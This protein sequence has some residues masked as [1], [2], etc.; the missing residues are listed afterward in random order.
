MEIPMNE[1]IERP[2]VAES[3]DLPSAG[4]DVVGLVDFI[5]E[6]G[7]GLLQQVRSQNPPVYDGR[8]DPRWDA[9]FDTLSRPPFPAQREAVNAAATLLFRHDAPAAVLNAEM[10]T[11]KTMM[12]I[13]LAAIAQSEGLRRT[14]VIS[15]P[16]LVYK[17]RREIRE[18]VSGARVWILNGPDTLRKLL[19]LRAA[20]GAPRCN[21]PEFFVLGRVRM[22]MGFHWQPAFAVRRWIDRAAFGEA[23]QRVVHAC[24]PRCGDALSRPDADG[25]PL[26]MSVALAHDMLSERRGHCER[27]GEALWTLIRPGRPQR[28][29]RDLVLDALQQMPTIGLKTAQRLLDTFG[30]DLLGGMLGDNVHEFLYLM[31]GQGDLVFTDR[32]AA[33]M[34]RALAGFEFSFGEGGYQPTEFIKR[35]LP[36]DYFGLLVVDE[37]HEYKNEGSAQGQAMG[38]LARKCRKTVLLTGTL[39]GGYADDLF[40]LLWRLNPGAMVE[41][42]FR[43]SERGSMAGATM[44]FMREHGVLKDIYKETSKTSHRTAKGDHVSH[45]VTK[46]PGF[47]PKGVMRYVLPITVFLKLKDI[48]QK[49]LPPYEEIFTGIRM[50]KDQ[51]QAYD[52]LAKVLVDELKAAL[53]LGD[54]TLLG[55]VL[56]VLLAWPDCAFRDETVCHPRTRRQLAF[57]RAVF[58]DTSRGPKEEALVELCRQHKAR[59]RRVLVYSVYS[60]TRDTTARLKAMLDEHGFKTAVLRASVDAAHREDW[61]AEQVDRGIDV[62]ICNPDLVKTGLDL[63]EFP[64]I[65]FMQSGYNVYTVQQAA[66]RSW[67]IGQRHPVEVHYLGYEGTAQM[68]CLKLMAKKIAVSQSTS[69][70]MPDSGLDVLNDAGD[71]IEV[72]LAKRMMG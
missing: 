47:G 41:D 33:R 58:D 55:V 70:D 57:Q 15:P 20:L 34:E 66:R 9:V 54:N 60:G 26:P 51:Q 36:Q 8:S 31:D 24:C 45:R 25:H 14:L 29:F 42:G 16:H 1:T 72:A 12:A 71:S 23:G 18:T 21:E 53:R 11:G 38:V 3:C 5:N 61:V 44:N 10:G 52:R 68:E 63:L 39:M 64:T 43:P 56:N 13:C 32:Q 4:A 69:G 6:F 28:S 22:R 37:G 67:R 49:V 27:C 7:A 59:R 65:A 46:A 19:A 30:E 35:Y 50:T 62:L 48:G 2:P 17:W 40:H